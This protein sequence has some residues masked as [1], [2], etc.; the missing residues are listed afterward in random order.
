MP[1]PVTI[2]GRLLPPIAEAPPIQLYEDS[3][4]DS[5]NPVASLPDRSYPCILNLADAERPSQIDL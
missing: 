3:G 2:V 4:D 5:K 1:E